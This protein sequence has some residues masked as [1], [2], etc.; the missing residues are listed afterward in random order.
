MFELTVSDE[1]AR[2]FETLGAPVAEEVASLLD[3]LAKLG[4]G[5][6]PVRAS[7]L[8]LWFDGTGVESQAA[9]AA[10]RLDLALIEGGQRLQELLSWQREITRC[11]EAPEFL[12]RLSKLDHAQSAQVLERVGDLQ[13]M[14]S[15]LRVVDRLSGIGL[16]RSGLGRTPLAL[17]PH[18]EA[19]TRSGPSAA[20]LMLRLKQTFFEVLELVGLDAKAISDPSTGLRELTIKSVLPGLRVLYGIDVARERI[21]VLLG[22]ALDRAYYGDSVRFAERR[23]REFLSEPTQAVSCP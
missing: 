18:V 19:A 6:D 23:F 12:A 7:R 16:T 17:G 3:V 9:P 22:E 4:P 14:R 1:F 11:L 15:A 5:L 21:L 10:L 20:D 8:L 2:W 13:Q